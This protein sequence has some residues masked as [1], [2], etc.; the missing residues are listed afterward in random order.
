MIR[1]NLCD[2]YGPSVHEIDGESPGICFEGF[3][4]RFSHHP[5]L[6]ERETVDNFRYAYVGCYEPQ[7][8]GRYREFHV[9]NE[10]TGPIV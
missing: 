3:K 4:R 7:N 9:V 8:A 5:D 2:D 10:C 1:S 6:I